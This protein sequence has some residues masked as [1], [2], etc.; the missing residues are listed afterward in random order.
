MDVC[1]S[2]HYRALCFSFSSKIDRPK[3]FY[4]YPN[5]KK[6]IAHSKEWY[7]KKVVEIHA[8]EGLLKK[9][10]DDAGFVRNCTCHSLRATLASRMYEQGLDEQLIQE[11]TGHTN[12]TVKRMSGTLKHKVSSA[13]QSDVLKVVKG[14]VSDESPK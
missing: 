14:A 2:R 3:Q 11:Q 10:T 12:R 13:L 7:S 4:F 6:L 8:I 5:D 9:M 1:V